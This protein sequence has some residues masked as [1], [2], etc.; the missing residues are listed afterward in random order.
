MSIP[1]H[2]CQQLHHVCCNASSPAAVASVSLIH[3][4]RSLAR[5]L[6]LMCDFVPCSFDGAA[7]P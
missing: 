3:S 2:C 1:G 5:K 4:S 6:I 7:S